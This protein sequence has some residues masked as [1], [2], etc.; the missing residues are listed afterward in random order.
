MQ[1]IGG[2]DDIDDRPV[3]IEN[4]QEV[5]VVAEVEQ[6]SRLGDGGATRDRAHEVDPGGHIIPDATTVGELAI[7]GG[8]E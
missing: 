8:G 2:G 6:T 7:K 4:G 1:Q 3:R 5:D